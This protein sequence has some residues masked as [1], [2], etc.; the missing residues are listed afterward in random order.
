MAITESHADIAHAVY[1]IE[2]VS[3]YCTHDKILNTQTSWTVNIMNQKI[4]VSAFKYN[5]LIALYNI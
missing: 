4:K 2:N 5:C 3:R 1:S